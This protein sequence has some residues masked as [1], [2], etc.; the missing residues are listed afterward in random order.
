MTASNR[1]CFVRGLAA[2]L[3][4]GPLLAAG[5]AAQDIRFFR[6]GTGSTAGTYFPIGTLIASVISNP[7][8]S[9]A[10]EDGGSC[11]VPGLI[12][13]AQTT[14][15][16]VANVT[17]IARGAIES[18]LAQSDVIRW[19][20]GGEGLFSG[21]PGLSALRLIA[22]LYPES[23]HLVVRRSADI[24]TVEGLRGKRVS[25]DTPGSGTRVD[26]LIILKAYGLAPTDLYALAVKPERA[27][28]MM[29]ADELDA[30]FFVGG[31]PAPAISDLASRALIDLVPLVGPAAA[32]IRKRDRF[33]SADLIPSGVYDGIGEIRTL[34]VGAQW[35]VDAR[36][37]A[38]LVYRITRALWHPSNR[39]LLDNGHPKAKLM[40]R[41]TALEGVSIPLHPGA[42]RYYREAGLGR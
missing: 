24:G 21:R 17:E 28:T 19:A 9:R 36:V 12:A 23:V 26:A 32:A 7:P 31:Y 27:V 41:E 18:G 13:V 38:E 39:K 29:L 33:F 25:L 40:R 42:E 37:D 4:A 11:G 22:N 6:I 20:Y 2:A 34:S 35:V 3:A 14:A 30:F 5:A 1:R 16:S 15:G 8:G 10:C